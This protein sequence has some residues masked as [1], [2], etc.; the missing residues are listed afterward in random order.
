MPTQKHSNTRGLAALG[1][2][3]KGRLKRA[4]NNLRRHPL[5]W[6]RAAWLS[7]VVIGLLFIQCVYN[8]RTTG[9]P[10]V[11][12][13]ATTMSQQELLATTNEYRQNAGLQPLKINDQL[14]H[15]AQEKAHDMISR[16]YWSHNAPDGTTPWHFFDVAGYNYRS[17]GENLAYGFATGSETVTAWM[18]SPAHR[19]NLL[20]NY[21]DVGFGFAS[22]PDYQ[23][24]D[25]T[26]VVAF[27]G[28]PAAVPLITAPVKP[29][30]TSPRSTLSPA[31]SRAVAG[32]STTH[33]NGLAIIA[34]GHANWGVYASIGLIIAALL[35]FLITHLELVRTGWYRGRRYVAMH[36][37]V[38]LMVLAS[39]FILVVH[40]TGGFIK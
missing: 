33:A 14:S 15:G 27:Y 5:H 36:P 21:T 34:S 22:G 39:A 16:D 29:M 37:L 18:N 2:L 17:A 9:Q 26:V 7:V 23:H 13:Y 8:L 24:G 30:T 31:P 11:L 10:H 4:K 20:G 25:N 19:E 35:G 6:R 32:E 40:A 3:Q 1:S 12:A 28:T 38:D